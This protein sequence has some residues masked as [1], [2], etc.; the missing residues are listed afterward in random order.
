[1]K[2]VSIIVAAGKNLEIGKDNDL[3][4]SL[5]RD[6]RFFKETTS[7][8]PVIMG[9]KNWDSIPEKWRPL[10]NRKNI[11]MSRNPELPQN[12]ILVTD[13]LKEALDEAWKDEEEEVFIIGGGQIYDLAL[14]E[15]K[16]DRMYITH[17]DASF[18]GA[19]TFFPVW[20]ELRWE[21]KL[22]FSHGADEKHDYGFEVYQY[23]KL[24]K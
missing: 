8:H 11:I 17:I 13:K 14:Q 3:M 1:M 22:L 19:H 15:D 16:V 24:I 12:E 9:R 2:L 7:G 21:R 18:P 10:P 5:P 20:D 6:M 23:D 4:W